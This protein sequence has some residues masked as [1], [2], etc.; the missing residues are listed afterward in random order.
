MAPEQAVGIASHIGPTTDIFSLGVIMYEMLTGTLPFG[1]ATI[2]KG[3]AGPPP[4]PNPPNHAC[5]AS[6]DA[7]CLRCLRL[8]PG[9]RYATA[10]D[11]AEDLRRFQMGSAAGENLAENN[12]PAPGWP[13][14]IIIGIVLGIFLL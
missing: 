3:I 7:I 4:P 1:P 10:L 12:P 8:E 14:A 2:S 9:D 6:L 11:L 13:Y 5:P